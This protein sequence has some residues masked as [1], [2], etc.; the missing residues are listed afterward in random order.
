MSAARIIREARDVGLRLSVSTSGR[1]AYDGPAAAF[2]QFKP[3]LIEN[4]EAILAALVAEN[5]NRLEWWK[6]PVEGWPDQITIHN[7][8]RDEAAV[9]YLQSRQG[10]SRCLR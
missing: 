8:V 1:I 2:E 10:A 3:I 5:E 9:I 6:V 7:I 4:R